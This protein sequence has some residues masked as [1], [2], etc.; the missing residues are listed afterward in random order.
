MQKLTIC[1]LV[2]CITC[3]TKLNV[4]AQIKIN[5]KI[6]WWGMIARWIPD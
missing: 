1:L 3:P 5:I 6:K 4:D 2:R